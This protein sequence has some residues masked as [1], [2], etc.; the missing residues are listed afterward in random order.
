MN[1]LN[2]N[3]RSSVPVWRWCLYGIL[4]VIVIGLFGFVDKSLLILIPCGIFATIIFLLFI[5]VLVN[6]QNF[7]QWIKQNLKW[8]ILVYAVGQLFILIWK[9][10]EWGIHLTQ[11]TTSH[12]VS[13]VYCGT[14]SCDHLR[15][16]DTPLA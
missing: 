3:A 10:L 6:K 11:A 5:N 7:K 8:L 9:W 1:M 12:R 13:S 14:T 16:V 4:L 2:L 15:Q